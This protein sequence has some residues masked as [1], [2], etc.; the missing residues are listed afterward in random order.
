MDFLI[1]RRVVMGTNKEKK[2]NAVAGLLLNKRGRILLVHYGSDTYWTIPTGRVEPE[3]GTTK[4]TIIREM[5]EEL[6]GLESLKVIT[7]LGTTPGNKGSP[8]GTPVWLIEIFLCKIKGDIRQYLEGN[9]S[10]FV[11]PVQELARHLDGLAKTALERYLYLGRK[12][13]KNE[14]KAEG[15]IERIENFEKS[16]DCSA[17]AC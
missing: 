8:K 13:G 3:D 1:D 14:R 5:S 2:V 6:R 4:A 12:G 15:A 9:K 17:L 10:I 7:S 16:L 11:E